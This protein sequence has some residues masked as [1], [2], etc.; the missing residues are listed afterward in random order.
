M[1]GDN[2]VFG[3]RAII[4]AV[5]NGISIDKVLI[6]NGLRGDLYA[7]LWALLK[8]KGVYYQFVPV[9]K[10]DRLTVGN[11]QGVVAF[12]S[13]ISY[14]DLEEVL[15]NALEEGRRPLI[16]VLDRVTDVRNFGAMSR[17]AEC[18]GVDAV[19]VPKQGS[20]R[21]DGDAIKTS[22]G[23]LLALKVCK[24]DNLKD[25]IHLLKAY[26]VR[27]VAATEKANNVYS[28]SPLYGAIALMMGNEETGISKEYLK[29]CDDRV[30]IPMYGSISSLNVSVS[31]GILLYEI[32]RQRSNDFE[33]YK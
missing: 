12:T 31:A 7:E 9:E 32:V 15:K 33:D 13:E 2:I 25:A 4:E 8:S 23:A 27:V 11:H 16:L 29:L 22:A 20:A 24:V 19:V 17:T 6:Q 10:L 3:F 5:K 28:K 18:V 26:G 1:K 14:Y 21:I 30:A